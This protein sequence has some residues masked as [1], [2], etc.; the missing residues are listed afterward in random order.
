MKPINNNFQTF[1]MKEF[2]ITL[3]T[4]SLAF[5]SPIVGIFGA[6]IF[7]AV[8]DHIFGVWKAYKKKEKISFWWGM[9]TSFTKAFMYIFIVTAIY[10]IDRAILN[11]L[12]KEIFNIKIS[13][14][15]SKII[16]IALFAHEFMS[17]NRNF[18]EVKGVTMFEGLFAAMTNT[19]KIVNEAGK[20]KSGMS[21]FILS[22][23]LFSC[24]A[25]WH[26]NKAISKGIEIKKNIDTIQVTEIKRDS[27]PIYI[28]K[29]SIR[30]EVIDRIIKKDSLI[31]FECPD[32]GRTKRNLSYQLKVLELRARSLRDSLDFTKKIASINSDNH[33]QELRASRVKYRNEDK[34]KLNGWKTPF[35]IFG[36]CFVSF[37]AGY[38]ISKFR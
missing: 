29:D 33:K 12:F 28:T 3:L 8:L 11:D 4:M 9:W 35:I 22:I 19:R 21:I 7:S 30:W 17:I 20:I 36:F 38:F 18:K 31:Y 26:Y 16:G 25:E 32:F 27:I 2:L 6:L 23:V 13:F 24:S 10:T 37:A 15:V 34:S 1:Q 14:I 5:F